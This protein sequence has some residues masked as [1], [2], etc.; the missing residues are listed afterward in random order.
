MLTGWT[1]W[2]YDTNGQFID[3]SDAI[4]ALRDK[5]REP[6]FYTKADIEKIP[7]SERFTVLEQNMKD[8]QE[9]N[10][11]PWLEGKKEE[12]EDLR[13]LYSQSYKELEDYC[14]HHHIFVSDNEH[15]SESWGVP[16]FDNRYTI[17]LSLREWSGLM[18]DVWNR[19]YE[20]DQYDYLDFYCW[21]NSKGIIKDSKKPYEI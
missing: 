14:V 10:K 19:I 15:Q 11:N 3:F 13:T 5:S 12:A 8:F 1:A 7:E 9:Y 21:G 17:Q 20:T 4:F 16:V 2:Q 18:A 6:K